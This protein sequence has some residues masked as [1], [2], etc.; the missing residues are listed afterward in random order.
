MG[1]QRSGRTRGETV[2]TGSPC[3][4][5]RDGRELESVRDG[6]KS[7]SVMRLR[8]AGCVLAVWGNGGRAAGS[9]AG[10]CSR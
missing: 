7:G 2:A 10:G 9:E 6:G 8:S 4:A 1:L 5:V 3:V